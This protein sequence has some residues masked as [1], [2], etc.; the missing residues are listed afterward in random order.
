MA[1]LTGAPIVPVFSVRTRVGRCRV[2]IDEPILV[3]RE[4]GPVD[5]N[6]PALLRIAKA[7][8]RQVAAHPDQWAVYERAWCEDQ[9]AV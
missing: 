5:A 9:E 7:I 6:H 2:I 4:S 8:E 1:L 3:S